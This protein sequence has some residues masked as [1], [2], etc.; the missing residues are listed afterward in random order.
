MIFIRVKFGHLTDKIPLAS[1]VS[2][3]NCDESPFSTLSSGKGSSDLTSKST[4]WLKKAFGTLKQKTIPK[5]N[6]VHL[7]SLI[8][9][10]I[11]VIF[12]RDIKVQHFK[13]DKSPG[14]LGWQ[15]LPWSFRSTKTKDRK[16]DKNGPGH[17]VQQKL[18]T[19]RLTKMVLVIKVEW[20]NDQKVIF[21]VNA[22]RE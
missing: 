10:H 18:K 20:P 7:S 9:F 2:D 21:E 8:W 15:K 12:G 3:T 19:R 11:L 1:L 5:T 22:K 6:G 13:I 16:V 14:Q 17:L 4:N